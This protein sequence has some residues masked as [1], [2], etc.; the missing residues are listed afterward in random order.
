MRQRNQTIA[1]LWVVAAVPFDDHPPQFP[2]CDSLASSTGPHC[3]SVQSLPKIQGRIQ[4]GFQVDPGMHQGMDLW[5]GAGLEP[6]WIVGWNQGWNQNAKQ[7]ALKGDIHVS[8]PARL[9]F[10]F[11]LS[12]S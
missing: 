11:S 4:G 2:H 9:M 6:G 5:V 12:T 1:D 8:H 7:Q 10:N 3:H